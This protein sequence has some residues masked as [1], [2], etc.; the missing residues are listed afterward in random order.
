[1]QQSILFFVMNILPVTALKLFIV[2]QFR[3]A[4]QK[5]LKPDAVP[6]MF[7]RPL[8]IAATPSHGHLQEGP[9]VSLSVG[10]ERD[11]LIEQ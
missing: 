10:H 4:M 2:A 9:S 3:L 1:M 7:H 8:N 5:H 6:T 11:A